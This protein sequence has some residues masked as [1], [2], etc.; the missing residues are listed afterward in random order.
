M[1]Q[2]D[3]EGGRVVKVSVEVRSGAARFRAAVWAQSI[4]RAASLV[5]ERYPSGEA[6]VLFPIDPEAFFAEGSQRAPGT[7]LPE[8]PEKA[9]G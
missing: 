2:S 6:K 5:N 9:A 1:G 8:M 7:V 4:E 3:Q